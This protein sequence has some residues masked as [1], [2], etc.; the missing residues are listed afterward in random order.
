[1]KHPLIRSLKPLLLLLA[2][3]LVLAACDTGGAGGGSLVPGEVTGTVIGYEGGDTIVIAYAFN[4][5]DEEQLEVGRGTLEGDTIKFTL[6]PPADEALYLATTLGFASSD[7]E[8]RISNL[9]VMLADG[10]GMFSLA[11]TTTNKPAEEFKVGDASANV[12]YADRAGTLTIREDD[13]ARDG[14][15]GSVDVQ[16]G[17]NVLVG[18]MTD[19]TTTPP[20]QRLI[21]G[22]INDYD[23]YY[24]SLGFAAAE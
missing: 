13:E 7:P 24:S 22:N 8:L 12:V 16:K 5:S 21:S 3:T 15:S 18:T 2:A 14:M 23:W 10:S 1:M 19:P 9:F 6:T 17:W 20:K 11:N 4:P